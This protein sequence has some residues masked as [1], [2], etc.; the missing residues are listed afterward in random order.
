M[1]ELRWQFMDHAGR[2]VGRPVDSRNSST[3]TFFLIGR[4]VAVVQ[5][6]AAFAMFVD[7]ELAA[8]FS[9]EPRDKQG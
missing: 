5:V 2:P 4:L 1:M 8:T 9:P 7:V 6:A 3:A